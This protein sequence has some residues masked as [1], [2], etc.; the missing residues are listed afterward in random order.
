MLTPKKKKK[1]RI[2]INCERTGHQYGLVKAIEP[3][4]E[5]LSQHPDLLAKMQEL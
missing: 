1:W 2:N 5:I 4:S 3:D